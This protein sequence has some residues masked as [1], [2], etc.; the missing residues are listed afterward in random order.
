[1]SDDRRQ[2]GRAGGGTSTGGAVEQRKSTSHWPLGA[3]AAV[4]KGGCR[5]WL[6]LGSAAHQGQSRRGSRRA[7]K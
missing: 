5:L 7:N 2:H 1:M 6:Q 3:P 4:G